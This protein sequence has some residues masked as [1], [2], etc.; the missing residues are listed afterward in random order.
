MLSQEKSGNPALNMDSFPAIVSENSLTSRFYEIHKALF[1][2]GQKTLEEKVLLNLINT[3]GIRGVG[4][5]I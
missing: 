1:V 3:Y 2:N 5:F 4:F